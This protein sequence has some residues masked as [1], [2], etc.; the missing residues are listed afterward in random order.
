MSTCCL[1]VVCGQTATNFCGWSGPWMNL[2]PIVLLSNN[3]RYLTKATPTCQSI[4][5]NTLS[6]TSENS[7]QLHILIFKN[8]VSSNCTGSCRH[9]IQL[10]LLFCNLVGF[11]VILLAFA[12]SHTL[13]A[14]WTTFYIKPPDSPGLI[15]SLDYTSGKLLIHT[16]FLVK[17]FLG[18]FLITLYYLVYTHVN[19]SEP[20]LC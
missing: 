1:S 17:P 18:R 12:V 2:K 19:V 16:S 6:D 7:R 5:V 8:D 14:S 10:S 20:P 9:L 13:L 4:Y 15:T 11:S 3:V